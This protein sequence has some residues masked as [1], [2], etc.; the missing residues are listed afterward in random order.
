VPSA[1][2]LH[3][4]FDSL[5]STIVCRSKWVLSFAAPY[6]SDLILCPDTWILSSS[7]SIFE[8]KTVLE[9]LAGRQAIIK[10]NSLGNSLFTEFFE[11]LSLS[12]LKSKIDTIRPHDKEI[13]I[14]EYV[15]GV[16]YSCGV[17]ENKGK[18]EALP[19]AEIDTKSNIF[20]ET[21]K[22]NNLETIVFR[23]DNTG[24]I[25]RIKH[26][27]LKLSGVLGIKN[28]CRFDYIYSNKK[29]YFL[30]AN[31]IPG[32]G[33]GSIFPKMLNEIKLSRIN[34][35]DICISNSHGD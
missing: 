6:L 34:F 25:E 30:E 17:L 29:L 32:L 2:N 7:A 14:Q 24:V 26:A 15:K 18:I 27:S 5:F 19:V 20:G 4:N 28:A 9:Q 8:M 11:S 1:L 33:K 16:E 12:Q 10:P 23:H 22:A 35:I 31:P 3:G 21:I 13:M